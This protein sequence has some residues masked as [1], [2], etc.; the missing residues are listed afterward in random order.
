MSK[1]KVLITAGLPYSNGDL[2]VGHIAGCYLPADIYKRYLTLNE[3]DTRYVCG[4]DD[5]GVAIVISGEKE[6]KTPKEIV[7]YFH[8]RQKA[9]FDGLGINFDV[10][11]STSRSEYHQELSNDFFLK[12]HEK[13]YFTKET[14]EQFY[15]ETSNS[16]LPDRYVKGDCSFCKATDQNGDQC[17]NCGKILDAETLLNP[18]SSLNDNPVSKK[19]TTHW[20]LDLSKAEADV[21]AWLEK[22]DIRPST[23]SYVESLVKAGLIKRS[24]TR[25]L[26]W[27][28][29]VPLEDPDAKNK[30]M[31]VWFD[32]PIGYI[33]NTKE[34]FIKEGKAE[35][36]YLNWWNS[37]DTDLVHFIGEDNTIFHCL[38]WIAMLKV[39]GGYSLPKGV[40]VNNFVNIKKDDEI[41]KISKSR[42][43]AR[44]VLEYL[45]EGNDPD[46]L[47]YYLSMI[48]PEKQRSTFDEAEMMSLCN[49]DLADTLGNFINRSISFSKKF[50][51]EDIPVFDTSLVG[52]EE[53]ELLSQMK[54]TLEKLTKDI[55]SYSTKS[56]IKTIFDFARECNRYFNEKAPWS[57]RKDDMEATKVTLAHSIQA[58]YFL[59]S[60]L[61]PFMP[62]KSKEVLKI[63]NIEN[64]V[65]W[66]DALN[67]PVPG[68]MINKPEILFVKLES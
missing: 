39:H 42:K 44:W 20:F 8:P 61:A 64:D 37:E 2:H 34:M 63:F 3:V 68:T 45:E 30:V 57:T 17:E 5:H 18:R 38:I 1:K 28:L 15:D 47:R 32:A 29:P 46:Y 12:I 54:S 35:D 19:P 25:D 53:K 24:M 41:Q 36:E 10:F 50:I 9:A 27:G 66:K 21:K 51:G 22:A 49:S 58:I 11:G 4:S 6:G 26:N 59:G 62:G 65:L 16:F 60:I 31:Y 33:S 48:S 14:T 13:G 56:A 52:H 55:E 23:K 43:N 40:I 7:D 67:L